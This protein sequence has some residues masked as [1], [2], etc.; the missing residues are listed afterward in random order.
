M[1]A[2]AN[3]NAVAT[4]LLL[5]LCAAGPAL[6]ADCALKLVASYDMVADAG[7]MIVISVN[8]AGAPRYTTIDTGSFANW[9]TESFVKEAKLERRSIRQDFQIYGAEE[10]VTDLVTVPSV[11]IGQ[12][13]QGASKFM[14][15]PNSEKAN[16]AAAFGSSALE[17]FDVEFDFAAK[18]VNF[19]SQDH[20]E[21]QVVYWTKAYTAIPFKMVDDRMQIT[22]TLDGHD[23]DT[24]LDTG[25]TYTYVNQRVA[26]GVFGY[27]EHS[28]NVK[29]VTLAGGYKPYAATFQ[30]LSIGGV[31]F[32][33]PSILLHADNERG[34]AREDVPVKDQNQAGDFLPHFPHILLGLDA[35]RQ[36]H[37]Y[38]AFK[39]H[40]VYVTAA[41][42]H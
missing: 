34:M 8:I 33:K 42:E 32:P 13:H 31:T 7:S 3:K 22:M 20:C 27:D 10:R 30:S 25:T 29:Q 24:L 9:V 6:A 35:L 1:A 36:L 15:L 11:D 28:P 21:G 2:R 40:K 16:L 4:A 38:I 18:K 12:V 41:G 37:L 5:T 23:F 14:I 17:Q 19:F 26:L 39:E